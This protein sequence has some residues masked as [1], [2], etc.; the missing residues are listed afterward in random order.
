MPS[1][2]CNL[3]FLDDKAA[4]VKTSNYIFAFW[5]VKESFPFHLYYPFPNTLYNTHINI[6]TTLCYVHF[7]NNGDFYV[8]DLRNY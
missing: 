3:F 6:R 4:N 2:N 7:S 5:Y 1:Q 8:E